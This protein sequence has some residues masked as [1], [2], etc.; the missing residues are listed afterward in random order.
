MSTGMQEQQPVRAR[1]F[2][3][4]LALR[5][6]AVGE[7]HWH[8]GVTENVSCSGVLLRGRRIPQPASMLEL[9]LPVPRQL[10]GE[11]QLIVLCRGRI[12]R[13]VPRK[14]P[15]LASSAGIRVIDYELIGNSGA[16]SWGSNVNLR[17][18]Q[19][20]HDLN[21]MLAVVIGGCEL[22]LSD[23]SASASVKRHAG[24]IHTAAQRS[25]HLVQQLITREGS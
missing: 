23:P 17:L 16:A 19:L 13:V 7:R 12:A 2:P 10:A 4:R 11:A 3:L 14:L 24:S 5:Y 25:A 18:P 22:I 20:V 6:R 9:L 1:R 8:R 21:N 15:L